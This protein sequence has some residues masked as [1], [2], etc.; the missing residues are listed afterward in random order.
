MQPVSQHLLA[1]AES[2]AAM[3]QVEAVVLILITIVLTVQ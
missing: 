2:M 3:V 1:V